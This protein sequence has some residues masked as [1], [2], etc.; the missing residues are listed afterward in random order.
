MKS[1]VTIGFMAVVA[2]GLMVASPAIPVA[3]VDTAMPVAQQNES[4]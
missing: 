2:A 1:I 4:P 3:A